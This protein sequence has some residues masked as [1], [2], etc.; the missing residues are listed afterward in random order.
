MTTHC[1]HHWVIETANGPI[2]VGRCRL[3]REEKEFSNSSEYRGSWAPQLRQ[4]PK[5]AQSEV[6]E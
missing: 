2:S 3:C 6:G 4:Y 5:P 1:S